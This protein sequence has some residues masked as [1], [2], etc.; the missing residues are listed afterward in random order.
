MRK[1]IVRVRYKRTINKDD[2]VWTV[3]A[4]NNKDLEKI[5]NNYYQDCL[6]L[7]NGYE[8]EELKGFMFIKHDPFLICGNW[9]G[10]DCMK[11]VLNKTKKES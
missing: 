8:Y 6:N 11:Y 4:K 1:Y 5:I 10:V 3:K 9:V 7:I 2:S